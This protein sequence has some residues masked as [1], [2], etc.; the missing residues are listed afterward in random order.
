MID[1]NDD[2]GLM[3]RTRHKGD[4]SNLFCLNED[5]NLASFSHDGTMHIYQLGAME[6]DTKADGDLSMVGLCFSS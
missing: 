5:A 3:D 6:V 4:I 1:D 2:N